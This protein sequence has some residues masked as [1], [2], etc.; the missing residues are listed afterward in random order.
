[1]LGPTQC[2]A[3]S[4]GCGPL[5]GDPEGPGPLSQARIFQLLLFVLL[6]VEVEAFASK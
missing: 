4:R 2:S 5:E 6:E 1:M 3:H